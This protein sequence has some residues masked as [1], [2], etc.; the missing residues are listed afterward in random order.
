MKKRL[1]IAVDGHSSCGKSSFAKLIARELEYIYI[2][3]GAM[4]RAVTLYC[5]RLNLV[6]QDGVSVEGIKKIMP[7]ITIAFN[8]NP[9]TRK[10]ETFL[11]NENVEEEI[12]LIEVSRL[13]SIV[14]SIKEVRERMVELQRE[15]G[16]FKGIVMDGRDIG[17]V[18][19]PD[20]EI[21]IFMTA[22]PE[23]RA[24]RRWLELKGMGIDTDKE[25]ILKNILERDDID[26]N[27]DISPL[28]KADDAYLLDN[29]EMTFDDQMNWFR[30]IMKNF[31]N[32]NRN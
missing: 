6:N 26:S 23:I 15:I 29:S 30:N 14:S 1:I 28:R 21:K 19:F 2:D 25:E 17:T 18:V 4:Y 31:E 32:E 16:V 3:S 24:H 9:D 10:Y 20:A 11:N 7:D 13:V 5:K 22:S 8:Y 27:R 12:R